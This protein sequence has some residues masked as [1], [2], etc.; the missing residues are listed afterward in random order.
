M[1]C[2]VLI[3]DDCDTTRMGL[4]RILRNAGFDTVAMA[5][6]AD[7]LAFLKEGHSAHVIVLDAVMPVMDGWT[8]R[9]A[10]LADPWIADIPVVALTAVTARAARGLSASATFQKPLDFRRLV[11]TLRAICR[12]AARKTK[13]AHQTWH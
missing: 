2:R 6:G 12:N 3:V 5:N 4:S 7:A 8:F 10:Q 11:D 1:P 9:R 13:R